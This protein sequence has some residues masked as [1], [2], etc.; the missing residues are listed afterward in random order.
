[1]KSLI[2]ALL[3]FAVVLY[4][5]YDVKPFRNVRR[6]I[7]RI[8]GGK[9]GSLRQQTGPLNEQDEPVATVTGPLPRARR[10]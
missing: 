2:L 9:T 3:L 8:P 4:G 7:R 10:R 5:C 6:A 1:M